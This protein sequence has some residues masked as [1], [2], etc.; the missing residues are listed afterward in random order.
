M[1]PLDIDECAQTTGRCGSNAECVNDPGSYDCVCV[2]G[3]KATNTSLAPSGSNPCID[4]DECVRFS[5]VVDRF[6]GYK[7]TTCGPSCNCTNTIGSYY[8]NCFDGYRLN[9]QNKIA[10]LHNPCL[11]LSRTSTTPA[12]VSALTDIHNPCLGSAAAAFFTLNGMESLLSHQYLKTENR[13]EMLSDVITAILP[14]MNNTNMTDPVNFTIQ[15]K[16]STYEAGMV[17]CVYWKEEKNDEG[18]VTSMGWSKDGCTMTFSNENYTVC[19]CVHLS[20]FALI[21]QIA[22]PPP[23]NDFLDWLNRICVIVGLFFF[24]LAVL[25]FLLCS[26]NPK[27]NNT[28]RLHLCLNLG[29]SHLLLLWN[30]RF[31]DDQ[32]E[33]L[34]TTLH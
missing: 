9:D 31:V 13:T 2:T 32:V 24:A 20:T 22:E 1:L 3:Y 8:C 18:V 16:R 19:S 4:M 33:P 21:L 26:W 6:K 10:S 17:T 27:I 15:H 12:S 14:S 34:L 28:A 25:T 11:V 7:Q 30:D 23:Q 29:L 5:I